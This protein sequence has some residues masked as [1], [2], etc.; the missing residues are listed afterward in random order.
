ME[1]LQEA[2]R[3]AAFDDHILRRALDRIL[4]LEKT[5][6]VFPKVSF[7][8]SFQRLT[9]PDLIQSL[10]SVPGIKS[11]ISFELI[12]S[13]FFDNLSDEEVDVVT[14]LRDLGIGIEI[15]DFGTGHASIIALTRLKPDLLK[16][17]RALI[18]PLCRH[19]EQ[20]KLIRAIV[21][22]A[23]GLGIEVLAEGVETEEEI[24]K[25][26]MI[27]VDYAQGYAFSKPMS[28][29]DLQGFLMR[30]SA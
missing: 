27:G 4:E 8:V 22:M 11:R 30:E 10:Q 20:I 18:S 23:Q 12:E 13:V 16:I 2:G 3:A 29:D 6:V 1:A 15:D 9:E 17:D 21:D 5:G 19:P 7:N 14:A 24:Q 25:L 28:V 26:R